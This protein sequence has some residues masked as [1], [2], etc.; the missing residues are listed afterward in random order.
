MQGELLTPGLKM[1]QSSDN[2][3][4]FHSLGGFD[5]QRPMAIINTNR[6]MAAFA[7][8]RKSATFSQSQIFRGKAP[9]TRKLSAKVAEP[10]GANLAKI[11]ED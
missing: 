11:V 9:G 4:G 8:H 7:N 10:G 3:H 5:G 2:L 1:V 6:D